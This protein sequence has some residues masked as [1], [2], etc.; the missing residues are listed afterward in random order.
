MQSKSPVRGLDFSLRTAL[1][2]QDA[3]RIIAR[4][5]FLRP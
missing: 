2:G 3:L 5:F 1:T 4:R